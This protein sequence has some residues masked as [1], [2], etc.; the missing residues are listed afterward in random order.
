[1]KKMLVIIV[2]AFMFSGCASVMTPVTSSIPVN[3][4]E[5][6]KSE[7][8]G[9]NCMSWFLIFGPFGDASI[10]PLIDKNAGKKITLIDIKHE[11]GNFS[12][13][14]CVQVYGY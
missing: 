10:K 4:A 2:S 6:A 3:A 12:R 14:Q 9:E 7:L 1:M 11:P 13:K 5:I 8:L